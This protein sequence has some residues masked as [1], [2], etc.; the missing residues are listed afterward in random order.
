MEVFALEAQPREANGTS[1]A[2]NLRRA[3][4]TPAIMYGGGTTISFSLTEPQYR[5]L[6]FSP[7]FR[8]VEI[9]HEG[10][11]YKCILKDIQF[12]PLLDTVRHLDFLILEPGK[13]FKA[14][15]PLRFKGVSAGVKVG[16]KF[17]ALVRAISVIT[18][19]E[20]VVSEIFADITTMELGSTIRVRD[21]TQIE[22]IQ[23]TNTPA[24][25]IATIE[26]PRALKSAQA[27]A[28]QPEGK[29]KK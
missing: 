9:T 12:D 10:K 1:V 13:K 11:K 16:G 26:I 23:I 29:K 18:T 28:N 27:A 6:I 20:Q 4:H 22:G 24:T 2:E 5:H 19:P 8:L 21:I 17:L 25:P 3:G 14:K 15:I 7:D